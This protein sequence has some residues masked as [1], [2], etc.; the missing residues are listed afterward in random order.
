[1]RSEKKIYKIPFEL[2]DYVLRKYFLETGKRQGWLANN[3]ENSFLAVSGG[4]DSIAL[5]WLF[6]K[7]YKNKF[8]V[9]HVNHGIRNDEADLDEKFVK[10]FAKS[11]NVEILIKKISV[12]DQ[13]LKGESIEA[14]ARRL[15]L[16]T[17]FQSVPANSKI[18]LGHNR[19][20]LAETVL[21]NILRGSGVRGAV[22]ITEFTEYKGLKF[23]RPL[24]GLRREFLREILRVR[25]ISWR[26]DSTNSDENY[27]RNFIRLNLL[28]LINSKINS[29]AIEHLASFGEDMRIF[30]NFEDERGRELLERCIP[31]SSVSTTRETSEF[32]APP[33]KGERD[34]LVWRGGF[35]RGVLKTL[36]SYERILIIREAGRRLKLKT[37]SR[38]RC[39][40]LAELI[41][42]PSNFIFQWE[43]NMNIRGEK[44]KILFS[45]ELGVR[46]EE[47][48]SLIPNFKCFCY[49]KGK[50]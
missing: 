30:R 3:N 48:K 34:K 18:F 22:G 40:E 43:E 10:D 25:N 44:D 33:D 27:T 45:E 11:L 14:A 12:P 29:S 32:L 6:H 15:R 8:S 24:L 4:G 42:K 46:G 1:M 9:I 23:Y 20:D 28:P 38:N 41:A 50:S 7:F 39:E 35:D 37:L 13:K 47:L 36:T 21:F 26:E 5:L 17:I 2:S 31:D 49:T 19:D 16:E